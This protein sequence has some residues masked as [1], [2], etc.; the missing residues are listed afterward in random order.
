MILVEDKP[1]SFVRN[2]YF[3]GK[4]LDADHLELE[5]RYM[6][7]KRWLVNRLALGMGVLT[8]LDVEP[9]DGGRVWSRP[10]V[11][12]DARGREIVVA[13]SFCLEHPTQPTDESG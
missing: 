6:N 4:L 2:R 11:A 1:R 7:E 12:L 8:G 13:E 3:W 9:A 5:Q 10:G